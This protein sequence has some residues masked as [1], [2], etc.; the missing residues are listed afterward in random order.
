M[1]QEQIIRCQFS[2]KKERNLH[3]HQDIEIIYVLD[4]TLD[5]RYEEE[6]HHMDTDDFLLVN[7][8][9]RHEYS[10]RRDILLGSIFIDYA[11]LTEM[12]GGEQLYFLC[13]S[14]QEKSEGYEKMRYYIRQIFNYYQTSEGQ[15]IVLRNSIFYQLLYILTSS[16]I[17]K[18]G[19]QKY[20]S[21]RGI[22]DERM[23]EILGYIMSNFKESIT[24]KELADK[25]YLSNAYL[26][27][28]IKRNFGMSF[29]KLVN[30]IRMEHAVSE[31]LYS[32]KSVIKIAMDNGFPNLA[33]FNKSF[34]E[35][36]Q[37][38][39]AQY[40]SQML[41]KVEKNETEENS[42]ELL[43]LVEQYLT[44][45]LVEAPGAADASAAI[46]ETDVRDALLLPQNWRK[47]INIG[48]ATDLLRFDVRDQ[49]VYLKQKL[50][51]EYVRFWN[52]LSDEMMIELDERK[53]KYNFNDLDKIFDFLIGIGLK[54]YMEIGFKQKEI[55]ENLN[56]KIVDV[57][58]KH[59]IRIIEKNK[60]FFEELIKHLVKRYGTQEVGT[61][62][63]ELE[64]N[65]EE[66]VRVNADK[67][68]DEFEIVA[69]IFKN[70]VPNLRIG[71]GGFCLN[72]LDREFE[73]ILDEWKKRKIKPDFL[74]LYSYPYIADEELIAAGRNPYSSDESFLNNQ[75]KQAKEI[76]QQ[77]G[78]A[79]PEFHVTEWSYTLSNRNILNDSCFKAA[80]VMKNL[81]Q[82][83]LEADVIGYWVATDI[84]SDYLDTK[85][86]LF[87]GCGLVTKDT[88]RKP[89]FFAYQFLNM[90]GKYILGRDKYALISFDG[91]KA[92]TI[93]CHNYKH[94]N[95]RYYLINENEIEVEHQ[96][97]L[98]EDHETRQMHFKINHV[99]NGSYQVKIY[100]VNN[101]YGNIQKEWKQ[102]G[103]YDDLNLQE[104]EYLK[105]ITQ[106]KIFMRQT[107]VEN[108]VLEI[109]TV[110]NS[111]EIQG[112]SITEL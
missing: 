82:N 102:V 23:N 32:D 88:I 7:S 86:I 60:G 83:C 107:E 6:S 73:Q 3:F 31:L 84:F 69:G 80:Y 78:L 8:N 75:I 56:R 52:I 64:K 65:S 48:S 12:F 95:F 57:L 76:M 41:E 104:M 99:N 30:N 70:Y 11:Q 87:G 97:R 5:I 4:G 34:R 111:Q 51:F 18:K 37:M 19:M 106:P 38:T 63:V 112:I 77:S 72:Y 89:A 13:N 21:L 53:T 25:L 35:M 98:F 42:E 50:G 91:K 93:C 61:W 47:M 10:A 81:I 45:N 67:Y 94:F 44:S 43:E 24:L 22:S 16:F 54:P 79:L 33:G 39:P 55:Y 103:Y 66:R 9:V 28:Y 105:S 2:T 68:F 15:G 49:I 20:D 71:G 36:Y 101:E 58:N 92:F 17:V 59:Q 14:A 62:Y 108:G 96:D 109:E 85:Q 46:L 1:K 40:R 100:S 74:S 110:L 29:L 90:S 26:S 27:K